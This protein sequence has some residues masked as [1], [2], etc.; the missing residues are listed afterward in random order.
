M[1]T[2]NKTFQSGNVLT[3]A[4]LNLL[5]AKIDE[6]INNWPS[7]TNPT[8]PQTPTTNT[9]SV[10]RLTES[11]FNA[12]GTKET[13]VLYIIVDSDGNVLYMWL[14]GNRI[15]VRGTTGGSANAERLTIDQWNALSEKDSD[16]IYVVTNADGSAI[17][18]VGV[19]G[20]LTTIPVPTSASGVVVTLTQEQ[21]D[22]LS[23]K[24]SGTLYFI[25]LQ[26]VIVK[27]YLGEKELTL[28]SGQVPV[29]KSVVTEMFSQGFEWEEVGGKKQLKSINYSKINV[30][31]PGEFYA[32]TGFENLVLGSIRT[33]GFIS[34]TDNT[35]NFA[36]MFA[37]EIGKNDTI[38]KKASIIT[39]INSSG[40]SG[41]TINADKV[42]L[43][44][45]VTAEELESNYL[46][47][48]QLNTISADIKAAV[49]NDLEVPDTATIKNAVISDIEAGNVT[50]TGTLHYNRIIGNVTSVS[51]TTQLQD[52]AYF[53]QF[54]GPSTA[55][56]SQ[57]PTLTLPAAPEVG[58]TLFINVGSKCCKL[59][60]NKPIDYF[61]MYD[62]LS[63]GEY[64]IWSGR[65]NTGETLNVADAGW[66]GV[67]QFIYTGTS[68]QQLIHNIR[69]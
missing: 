56:V 22:A 12:L 3:A 27:A 11:E 54:T 60:A 34:K 59:A 67:V 64:S 16:K 8:N 65:I 62:E 9:K 48:S 61:Y 40:E 50:I 52:A 39:A 20:V 6:I 23:P 13:D 5:T 35:N 37:T 36:E 46:K 57:Y 38:V 44:G 15:S 69:I 45:Y 14:N 41:V 2:L 4:E 1:S 63:N 42:N 19:G 31:N 25:E 10:V 55:D 49:I 7:S 18:G 21:Y 32:N 29:I 51:S 33:A 47:S 66:N 26:G 28:N 24:D 53:V 30:D 68:W 58:Q 43:Q 17:V